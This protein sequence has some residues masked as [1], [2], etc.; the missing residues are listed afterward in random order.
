VSTEEVIWIVLARDVTGTV[1]V[2]DQPRVTVALILDAG[3]GLVRGVSVGETVRPG[4]RG[5]AHAALESPAGPLPPGPPARVA[6]D[7]AT[8]R[9]FS[10]RRPRRCLPSTGREPT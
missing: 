7:E 6:F 10:P 9:R 4:L 1:R 3:T 8:P 5:A 2:A